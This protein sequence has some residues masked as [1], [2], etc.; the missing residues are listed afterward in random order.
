MPPS[1]SL[2]FVECQDYPKSCAQTD[3]FFGERFPTEKVIHFYS[4]FDKLYKNI[5]FKFM[6]YVT[7]NGVAYD[8]KTGF[9]VAGKIKNKLSGI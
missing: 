2:A 8:E 3:A 7:I 9:H 4:E 1:N 5:S 6:K